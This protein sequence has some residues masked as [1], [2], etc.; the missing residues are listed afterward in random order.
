MKLKLQEKYLLIDYEEMLFEELLLLR[1]GAKSV[2]NYTNK[3]HELSIRSRVSDTERQSI[4]RYK[5]GLRK[6][7]LKELIIVHLTSIE[8]GSY[9]TKG[10]Q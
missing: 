1:Q 10:Q 3:F 8:E 9:I 4:A 5:V 7:I 2:D 6:D